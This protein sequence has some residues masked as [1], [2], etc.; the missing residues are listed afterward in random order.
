MP[1]GSPDPDWS[2]TPRPPRWS[3]FGAANLYWVMYDPYCDEAPVC[4][5]LDDDFLD[6][7]RD[8]TRG[9]RLYDAGHVEAAGWEWRHS[10]DWHWGQHAV[11]ALRALHNACNMYSKERQGSMEVYTFATG[12]WCVRERPDA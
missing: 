10:F 3:G 4:G 7:Y 1:P 12:R 6:T 9:L 8:L 2:A 5:S 11:G